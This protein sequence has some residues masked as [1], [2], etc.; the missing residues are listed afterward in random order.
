MIKLRNNETSLTEILKSHNNPVLYYNLVERLKQKK[1][2]AEKFAEY[3]SKKKA[4]E[5]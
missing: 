4:L 2:L 1:V 5:A 3:L